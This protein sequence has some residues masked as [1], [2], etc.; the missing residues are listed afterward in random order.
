MRCWTIQCC[1]RSSVSDWEDV[2]FPLHLRSGDAVLRRLLSFFLKLK[3]SAHASRSSRLSLWGVGVAEGSEGIHSCSMSQNAPTA[4]VRGRYDPYPALIPALTRALPPLTST[5][6]SAAYNH[7]LPCGHQ[8]MALAG[9]SMMFIF[10]YIW[11]NV[12]S[13]VLALAGFFEI[14]M[15]VP[16]ALFFWSVLLRQENIDFLQARRS[17]SR[18]SRMHLPALHVHVHVH[19]HVHLTCTSPRLPCTA[20]LG[21]HRACPRARRTP[22]GYR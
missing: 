21:L 22:R 6:V 5:S 20:R 10:G 18:R 13:L 11:F 19:V 12:G 14:L 15:S 7:P 1:G 9:F 8:D 3:L 2:P 16:L 4:R 17:P